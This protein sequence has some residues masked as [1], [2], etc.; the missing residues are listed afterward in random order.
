MNAGEA[1]MADP[2]TPPERTSLDYRSGAD[3]A[4]RR[5]ASF[6]ARV[7]AGV[8]SPLFIL[9]GVWAWFDID[10][11][12]PSARTLL[13]PGILLAVVGSVLCLLVAAGTFGKGRRGKP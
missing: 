7:A 11:G 4:D 5:G 6:P 2:P 13:Q 8:C 10:R 12:E 3:E 9:L 1:P